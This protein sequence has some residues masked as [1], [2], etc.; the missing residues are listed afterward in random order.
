MSNTTPQSVTRNSAL[1][2]LDKM[3]Y[4]SIERMPK[5]LLTEYLTE[6]GIKPP[7]GCRKATLIELIH[8]ERKVDRK[9]AEITTAQKI[10]VLDAIDADI[11]TGAITATASDIELAETFFETVKRLTIAQYDT[12]SQRWLPPS[13]EVAAQAAKLSI[14]VGGLRNG[15]TGEP[16]A[17]ETKLTVARNVFAHIAKLT[18]RYQNQYFYETLT[19]NLQTLRSVAFS[20]MGELIALKKRK[21]AT[22]VIDRKDSQLPIDVSLLLA[23]ARHIVTEPSSSWR[24]LSCAIALLTGRRMAEI[25]QSA[26]FEVVGEYELLFRGQLKEKGKVDSQSDSG[27]VIPTLCRAVYAVEALD[28]LTASGKRIDKSAPTSGVNARFSS[29]LGKTAKTTFMHY[30]KDAYLLDISDAKPRL[31]YHAFRQLYALV[32]SSLYRPAN[33]QETLYMSRILGHDSRDTSTTL[34]YASDFQ[35]LHTNPT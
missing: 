17:P 3:S 23:H 29:D 18:T 24:D 19:A 28:R 26:S 5:P 31:K 14:F 6:L 30:A 8:R 1:S 27:Y 35:L 16:L 11:L 13:P 15:T 12:A 20:G 9:E 2:K 32:A 10:V 22:A 21:A 34:L 33:V 25:H 4:S 7:Y